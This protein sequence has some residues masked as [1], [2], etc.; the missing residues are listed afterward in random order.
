MRV[1]R[2]G[3][4]TEAG[5]D[6]QQPADRRSGASFSPG[7]EG[8]RG[9][10]V[11]LVVA[12]HALPWVAGGFI[13]VDVFF[14]IS[15]YLITGLLVRELVAT[16]R[17][18]L[19]AF[20][21]RRMRRLLPAATVVAM[22]VLPAGWLAVSPLDRPGLALDG[23]GAML[24][25]SN[26]RFAA[27]EGDY[28]AAVRGPSPFLHYWSLSLEEQF[29]LVWPGLLLLVTR[30]GRVRTAAVASLVIV[31]IGSLAFGAWLT[32]VAPA[33]GFY[34][35]PSRAWQFALGGLLAVAVSRVPAM[36]GRAASLARWAAALVGWTGLALVV[37]AVLVIDG[38]QPYPGLLALL[39][40]MGALLV[41]AGS[42]APGGPVLLLG[43]RPLRF[44][45]RISYSLYLWHWPI[46]VIPAAAAGVALEWPASLTLA[47]LS[48][49]V[50]WLSWRYV[51]E[52]F[53]RAGTARPRLAGLSLR[54]GTAAIAGSV[55]WAGFF[56]LAAD[57]G[58]QAI[59]AAEVGSTADTA[60]D[61]PALV[62]L[63]DDIGPVGVLADDGSLESAPTI[64]GAGGPPAT[65]AAASSA[66]GSG[67]S[68]PGDSGATTAR[69]SASPSAA[70]PA[71]GGVAAPAS[72]GVA[73]Q[74]ADPWTTIPHR[75]LPDHVRLAP[76]VAPSLTEARTD[77]ERLM[78]DGCFTGLDG[79]QPANCVYGDRSGRVTV[80]LIGDSHA[81]HWF[82]AL[83]VLARRSGWR[84]VPLVKASCPFVDVPVL[85]P[86]AD[87]VYGSCGTWRNR[88]IRIANAAHP[89][90]VIVASAHL[91]IRPAGGAL[92]PRRQGEAMADAIARLEA[93]VALIVDN[94]RTSTDVPG[95][96]ARHPDDVHRCAIPR[97]EALPDTFGVLETVAA[98]RSGAHLV[99]LTTSICPSVPCAVVRDGMILYRDGHH[100][101]ATFAR[102]L[103]SA[104]GSQLAPLLEPGSVASSPA[105]ATLP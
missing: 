104:L 45:G 82:P 98:R 65:D 74:A 27:A 70:A 38:Y 79:S 97:S 94:P 18:D 25:V 3:R 103:A 54:L 60:E 24:I 66:Q 71:S 87:G 102:S 16:G 19:A 55:L 30:R 13:G 92:S 57:A 50:A 5:V 78:D 101:T 33:W 35:L 89:D 2:A 29:Y 28:F 63:H 61:G 14:V 47:A 53:R 84:L 62:A 49:V 4:G 7:V 64:D 83:N 6:A 23:G 48:V 69:A 72:G 20:Y 32:E 37:L 26:L 39:P 1:P 95:C 34:S 96:L 100:L 56:G 77:R 81:A 36:S 91:G 40:S 67:G 80:V 93:P 41:I 22:V 31:G 51:E 75:D 52:P 90:L 46:L 12:F 76:N 99:D 21:G 11:L 15:G 42:T 85:N 59:A 43:S 88:A 9:V 73:T 105:T 44:L 8:L 68:A 17:I 86:F 58:L 10:A